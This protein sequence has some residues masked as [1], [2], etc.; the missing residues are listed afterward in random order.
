MNA[1]SDERFIQLREKLNAV[2]EGC[3]NRDNGME[4]SDIIY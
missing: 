4:H 2:D 1:F 3:K